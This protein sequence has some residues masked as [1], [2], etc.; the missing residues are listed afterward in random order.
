MVFLMR[1]SMVSCGFLLIKLGLKKRSDFEKL[2]H[3][4]LGA[5]P[6]GSGNAI[7]KNVGDKAREVNTVEGSC[8]MVSKGQKLPIDLCRLETAK[9]ETIYSFLSVNWAVVA[10]IDL[11]SEKY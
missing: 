3:I 2:K 10:D 5:I 8:Y 7:V 11:E 6:G 1:S 9:G 4:P